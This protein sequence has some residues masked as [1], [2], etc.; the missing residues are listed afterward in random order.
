MS[1]SLGSFL[2][3]ARRK[4]QGARRKAQGPGFIF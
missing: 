3:G 1:D 2:F 4:A